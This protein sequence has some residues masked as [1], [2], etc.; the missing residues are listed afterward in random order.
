MNGRREQDSPQSLFFC[1]AE[2]KISLNHLPD[3]FGLFVRQTRQIQ[4]SIHDAEMKKGTFSDE[5]GGE[6][7]KEL[8]KDNRSRWKTKE[9]EGLGV[10]VRVT[11]S[12]WC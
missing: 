5:N 11:F 3:V 10:R 9:Q 12:V 1:L 8:R 4:F 2:V 6:K 7:K